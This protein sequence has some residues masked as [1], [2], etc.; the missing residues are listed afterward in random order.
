MFVEFYTHFE[1]TNTV[2]RGTKYPCLENCHFFWT[3]SK[4]NFY[5]GMNNKTYVFV[6]FL[7]SLKQEETEK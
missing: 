7:K 6:C 2:R 1:R 4:K 5:Q 3:N